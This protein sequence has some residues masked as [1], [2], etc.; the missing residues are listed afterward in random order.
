[1]AGPNLVD[2]MVKFA[3][4]IGVP[5]LACPFILSATAFI[6]AGLVLF[7][8]LRPDPLEIA[9]MIEADRRRE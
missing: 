1:M 2:I 7:V 9:R 3:V 5:V 4:S 6:L 8:M